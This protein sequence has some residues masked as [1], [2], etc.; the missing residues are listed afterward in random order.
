MPR[1]CL[2][3]AG[4][5]LLFI[6]RGGQ[7]SV[8]PWMLLWSRL[9]MSSQKMVEHVEQVRTCFL[10]LCAWLAGISS[11]IMSRILSV[12]CS[13]TLNAGSNRRPSIE[14]SFTVS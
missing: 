8:T 4:S 1:I 5:K 12:P 11:T 9:R 2:K 7:A 14:S 3:L 10:S 6:E 13:K